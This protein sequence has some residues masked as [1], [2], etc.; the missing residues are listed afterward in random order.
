MFV[1]GSV[2]LLRVC[3]CVCVF[4]HVHVHACKP[5]EPS[6]MVSD[7]ILPSGG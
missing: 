7:Q 4:G 6:I 2:Y 1:C 3:L 5:V